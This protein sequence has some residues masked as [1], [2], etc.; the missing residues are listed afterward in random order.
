M[1]SRHRSRV[2]TA[3]MGS[4][5]IERPQSSRRATRSLK[6][7][8]NCVLLYNFSIVTLRR[9]G[10]IKKNG[11]NNKIVLSVF[12]FSLHLKFTMNV[13]HQ[14]ACVFFLYNRSAVNAITALPD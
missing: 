3:L 5:Y 12:F 14:I 8:N 4:Q 9:I 10:I 6:P 7:R 2:T 13:I 1:F 11:Q